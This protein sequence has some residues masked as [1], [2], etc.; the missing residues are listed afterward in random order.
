MAHNAKRTEHTGHKGS[1]RKSGYYGL[2]A[3]AKCKSNKLRRVRDRELSR[4]PI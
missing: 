3:D 4:C 2:R 1:T